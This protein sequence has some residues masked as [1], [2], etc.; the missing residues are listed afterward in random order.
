MKAILTGLGEARDAG[1]ALSRF[2]RVAQ[3]YGSLNVE[4]SWAGAAGQR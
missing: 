3:L 4:F 1:L 2:V